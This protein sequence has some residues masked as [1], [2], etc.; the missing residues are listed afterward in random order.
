MEGVEVLGDAEMG[1]LVGF[2]ELALGD[3]EAPLLGVSRLMAPV[4]AVVSHVRL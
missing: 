3:E 2:D 1:M 4:I